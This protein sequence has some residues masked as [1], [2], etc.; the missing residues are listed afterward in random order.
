MLCIDLA[1]KKVVVSRHL[2]SMGISDWATVCLAG[3]Y[4]GCHWVALI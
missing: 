2:L 3:V 4:R 1:V